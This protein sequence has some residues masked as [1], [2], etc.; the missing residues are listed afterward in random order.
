MLD[1]VVVGGGPA[2]LIAARDL[3]GAGYRVVVVEEHPEIGVPVQ[4]SG[5]FSL[6]GLRELELAPPEDA[7]CG[8][9]R[10]GRFHSPGGEVLTAHS[11]QDRALVVER[12]AFDRYL[13]A[14][15]IDAGA[16]LMLSTR[17]RKVQVS[18]QE[19]GIA[20]PGRV[21][22]AH[23][24]IGA[25]GV[26]SIVARSCGLYS[27]PELVGAAQLEL[28]AEAQEEDI[29]DLFFGREWA[30][31]FYAW[32]L[33]KGDNLLAGVGVS[34]VRRTPLSYLRHFL[35]HHP[36]VRHLNPGRCIALHR[37]CIPVSLPRATCG[38]R[39]LLAGDAGSFVKA[40]TG[41]GVITGGIS[42]RL[43]AEAAIRAL[44]EEDFSA[45]FFRESYERRWREELL[46]ELEAHA[47]LRELMLSLGDREIDRLFRLAIDEDLPAIMVRFPD[48]DR[49]SEFLRELM[50]NQRLAGFLQQVLS[51]GGA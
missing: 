51:A 48:T 29:A 26:R 13:A 36:A 38:D 19:A 16:E 23:L 2:G 28:R 7:V 24:I 42:A 27:R 40:S 44:E 18:S 3:A 41:G 37:G 21:L 43:A 22:K 6:R 5:L 45:S 50:N 9:I 30:P 25:D 11:P 39:V 10:G 15:A 4:C 34:G 8:V 35:E 14:Q 31:G 17:V 20:L 46:R 47:L 49:P 1:A 33:P 32:V 12:H